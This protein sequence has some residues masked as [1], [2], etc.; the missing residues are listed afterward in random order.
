MELRKIEYF[1]QRP[2]QLLHAKVVDVDL[3]GRALTLYDPKGAR[4]QP[5][6]HVVP[7]TETAAGIVQRRLD[8][9]LML[10]EEMQ[11]NAGEV[12]KSDLAA[13]WLFTTDGVTAV[14][15][16]T[17]S[18]LVKEISVAMVREKEA[19]E[20]WQ[21]RDLRRTVETMLA[22]LG[23][24]SDLRAQVQSHGLGGVQARHYDQHDYL[25]EKAAVLRLWESH[26]RNVRL[27]LETP[28]QV[29]KGRTTMANPAPES[30]DAKVF[31]SD[32][33]VAPSVIAAN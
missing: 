21:L 26:L 7:L 28:E 2:T 27:G 1:G 5:R 25:A 10:R 13:S 20:P 3:P 32:L 29:T 18:E 14:R 17:V 31:G 12:P 24:V 22:S 19:R 30:T 4:A 6:V 33:A 9:N 23:T 8:A 15:E 11:R 16:E